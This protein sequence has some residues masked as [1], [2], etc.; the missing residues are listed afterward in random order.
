[1]ICEKHNRWI[2]TKKCPF[3]EKEQEELDW[4]V[5][6]AEFENAHPIVIWEEK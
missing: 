5:R 1:M 4:E 6:L 3:C 2:P